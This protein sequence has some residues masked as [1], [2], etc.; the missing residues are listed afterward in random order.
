MTARLTSTL[1]AEPAGFPDDSHGQPGFPGKPP[2]LQTIKDYSLC[3]PIKRREKSVQGLTELKS[4]R[5]GMFL[6][7]LDSRE[8]QQRRGIDVD[9]EQR[10]E[11]GAVV[12][13]AQRFS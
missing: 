5:S 1:P 12:F 2:S 13:P 6:D 10:P 9:V 11:A 8:G 3:F 4:R 7:V